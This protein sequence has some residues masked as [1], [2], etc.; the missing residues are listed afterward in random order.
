MHKD[1]DLPSEILIILA[2]LDEQ[3]DARME[4]REK[5]AL[6]ESELEERRR[7]QERKHEDRVQTMLFGFMQN[8][9]AASLHSS[10]PQMHPVCLHSLVRQPTS[11]TGL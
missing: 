4:E 7:D 9:M 6:L 8:I 1:T 5:R 3:A 2:K 10:M 11:S